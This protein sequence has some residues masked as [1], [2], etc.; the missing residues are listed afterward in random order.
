MTPRMS[1]LLSMLTRDAPTDPASVATGL[2][3]IPVVLPEDYVEAVSMA[4]GWRGF[5][6]E[7]SPYV[8]LWP[9]DEVMARNADY[10]IVPGKDDML[11]VGS[12]GGGTAYAIVRVGGRS[13]FADVPFV[14]LRVGE[15]TLRGD[16]LEE[17]L[18]NLARGG[19]LKG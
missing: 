17:F 19:H 9:I 16:S 2:R 11:L 8:E 1:E 12:D 3:E 14:P 10:E 13:V 15:A 7:S 4:S 6:S 5:L 18:E